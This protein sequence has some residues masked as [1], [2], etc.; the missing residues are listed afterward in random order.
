MIIYFDENMPKH[1]AKGFQFIQAPEGLKTGLDITIKYLPEVFK[2]GIKDIDWIPKV[3]KEGSCVITQDTNIS[4][5]KD[6]LALYKKYSIGIFFLKG[7]SK[8]QG[9]SIWGMTQALSKN[10]SEICL[11]ATQEKGPFGYEFQLNRRMKRL[12]I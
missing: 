11:K 10:W 6:E 4:K 12:N 3:G 2:S 1:L 5:R 8:K 9:L 7:P